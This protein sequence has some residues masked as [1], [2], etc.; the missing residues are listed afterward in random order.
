MSDQ[1]SPE[2]TPAE[3]STLIRKYVQAVIEQLP[4]SPS[5]PQSITQRAATMLQLAWCDAV[6]ENW[7]YLIASNEKLQKAQPIVTQLMKQDLY[8][9]TLRDVI[10]TPP[11]MQLQVC[12]VDG[13]QATCL[14]YA[15]TSAIPLSA[16]Y[17]NKV[18]EITDVQDQLN[19]TNI[20]EEPIKPLP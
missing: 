14:E 11:N 2:L 20:V 10:C 16:I 13:K 7:A 18:L 12:T 19:A 5:D 8:N 3:V 4:I 17:T 15:L 6:R 9:D 1:P